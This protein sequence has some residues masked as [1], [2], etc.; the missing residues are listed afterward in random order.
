MLAMAPI[1]PSRT[2][3]EF[4][5]QAE[6]LAREVLPEAKKLTPQ[7]EWKREI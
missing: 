6:W 3:A 7:G 1:C 4:E 2:Y 5:E